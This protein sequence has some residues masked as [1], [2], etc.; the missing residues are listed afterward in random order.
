MVTGESF[1]KLLYNTLGES[2][3]P[4]VSLYFLLDNDWEN[5][6]SLVY[7]DWVSNYFCKVDIRRY[8][9]WNNYDTKSVKIIWSGEASK[10]QGFKLTCIRKYYISSNISAGTLMLKRPL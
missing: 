7:Y 8:T 3:I 1:S 9:S 6:F 5:C 2:W 10:E 4:L